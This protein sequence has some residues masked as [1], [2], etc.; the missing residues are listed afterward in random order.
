MN[1]LQYFEKLVTRAFLHPRKIV[2]RYKYW[3]YYTKKP[4]YCFLLK[5]SSTGNKSE[6]NVARFAQRFNCNVS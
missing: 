6:S 4:S 5:Q 2:L 3:N 1:K